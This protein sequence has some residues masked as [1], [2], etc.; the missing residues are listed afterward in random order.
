MAEQLKSYVI[1]P[2]RERINSSGNENGAFKLSYIL[3]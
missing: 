1:T 3:I 2:P